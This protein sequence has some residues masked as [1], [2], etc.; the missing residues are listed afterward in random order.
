MPAPT[1][2]V[3]VPEARQFPST[4]ESPGSTASLDRDVAHQR[5]VGVAVATIVNHTYPVKALPNLPLR[6]VSLLLGAPRGM[7]LI[8]QFRP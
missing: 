8:V 1:I 7:I 2:H 3:Y 6:I 5:L 4:A